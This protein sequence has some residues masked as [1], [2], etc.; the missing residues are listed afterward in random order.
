MFNRIQSRKEKIIKKGHKIKLKT[1]QK[2]VPDDL[3]VRCPNCEQSINKEGLKQNLYKCENCNYHFR[4]KSS[5]RIKMTFDYFEEF[6]HRR[7]IK[8]PLNF[9]KYENKLKEL[10]KNEGINEAVITGIAHIDDIRVVAIVMDSFFLMGSMGMVVGEKITKA[11]EKA[12][13]LKCPVVMFTCSGGAR[14]QEG[15]FSLMQMAKTSAIVEKFS[16]KNLLFINVLTDPTTGGVS[17]SFAMLADVI[18]AE[19]KALIGFA[20][21]RVIEQTIQQK[22]PENF[23]KSELV[24]EQGFVDMIVDREDIKKSLTHILRLHGE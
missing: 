18:I 9:P 3:F 23:Q 14:M 21:P 1:K 4:L 11:F 8:N 12:M 7:I 10:G 17:A 16:Q 24:L 22:L 15:M 19:P 2:E 13:K 6:N 20:G 5:N